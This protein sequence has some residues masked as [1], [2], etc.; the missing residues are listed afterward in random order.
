MAEPQVCRHGGNTEFGAEVLGVGGD[1]VQG[2]GCGL[3]HEIV[4][5]GLVLPGDVGDLGGDS[6]HDVVILDGQQVALSFGQPLFGG[7]ALALWAMPV[8]TRV[9]SDT[10]GGASGIAAAAIYA[11]PARP[12]GNAR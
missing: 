10:R 9:V 5:H 7:G 3:E 6:E 8:A 1:G 12:S 11:R 2:L 4:D